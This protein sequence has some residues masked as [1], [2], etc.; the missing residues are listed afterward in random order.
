[1]RPV[2]SVLLVGL[3]CLLL[4]SH[5]VVVAGKKARKGK[6]GCGGKGECSKLVSHCVVVV[7]V[8]FLFFSYR[9]GGA[10]V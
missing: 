5:A 1:M 10:N 7:V 6:G 4:L 9:S 3:L 2:C 8:F